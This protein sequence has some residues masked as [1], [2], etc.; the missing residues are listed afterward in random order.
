MALYAFGNE[1]ALHAMYD[2][3]K[4]ER[5][6]MADQ[7]ERKT[8]DFAQMQASFIMS[9]LQNASRSATPEDRRAHLESARKSINSTAAYID[10][11]LK[12]K[13]T[14]EGRNIDDR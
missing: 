14:E 13:I 7:T 10:V 11:M 3:L 5:N 6:E 1:T 12:P 9:H 4:T 2:R 8:I